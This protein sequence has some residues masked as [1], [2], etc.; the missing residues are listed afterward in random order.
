MAEL[1]GEDEQ[2]AMRDFQVL[3]GRCDGGRLAVASLGRSA[4][5]FD[6]DRNSILLFDLA[7]RDGAVGD[8]EDALDQTTFRI[9]G[10][11]G[12]LRHQT[13]EKFRKN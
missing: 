6:P 13:S 3:R 10:A 4:E 12:K 7:N 8:I 5:R 1:L 9:A 11:I 2:L